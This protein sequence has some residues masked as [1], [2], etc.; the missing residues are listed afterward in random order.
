MRLAAAEVLNRQQAQQQQAEAQAAL[1][2]EASRWRRLRPL[3]EPRASAMTAPEAEPEL[4]P[5]NTIQ[6]VVDGKSFGGA[7]R[8]TVKTLSNVDRGTHT[9]SARVV[10][11]TGKTLA[12][13]PAMTFHLFRASIARRGER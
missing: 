13:T 2:A 7:S 4:A 1:V 12:T 10:N 9:L 3:L 11:E 8:N 6:F 5:G